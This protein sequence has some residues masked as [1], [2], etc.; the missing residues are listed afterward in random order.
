MQKTLYVLQALTVNVPVW[1]RILTTIM[2]ERDIL[3]MFAKMKV[4][5]MRNAHL[6][7]TI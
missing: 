4:I 6:L 5:M 7:K 3:I 1:K 2:Q